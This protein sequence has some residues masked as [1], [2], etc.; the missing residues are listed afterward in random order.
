MNINDGYLSAI[1]SVAAPMG[2]MRASGLGRR[3]GPDGIL[4]YTESQTVAAQRHPLPYPAKP[5]AYLAA[6][7]AA[8]KAQI[9]T[10]HLRG[11]R[12]RR[13]NG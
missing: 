11:R 12:S 7:A 8:M 2:G 6:G 10:A 5:A 1:G 4:R 9:A 13:S 3:H